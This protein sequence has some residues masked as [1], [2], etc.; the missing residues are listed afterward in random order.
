MQFY[1]AIFQP[2]PDNFID[3]SDYYVVLLDLYVDL[4]NLYVTF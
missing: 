1:G 2:P 4:S 3:L